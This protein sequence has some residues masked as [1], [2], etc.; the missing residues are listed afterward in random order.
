MESRGLC[1]EQ[2][3]NLVDNLN[4]PNFINVLKPMVMVAPPQQ[5]PV[6]QGQYQQG[7]NPMM[8][9]MGNQMIGQVNQAMA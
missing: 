9:M 5:V 7:V 1:E 8:N 4:N 2:V 3:G 6:M